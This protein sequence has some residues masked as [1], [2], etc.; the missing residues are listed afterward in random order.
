MIQ[1][2]LR[3]QRNMKT[4]SNKNSKLKYIKQPILAWNYKLQHRLP[5]KKE[6]ADFV[7]NLKPSEKKYTVF[8]TK[9]FH[10]SPNANWEGNVNYTLWEKILRFVLRKK[11]FDI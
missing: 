11:E 10:H 8:E 7:K 1:N 5:T 4:K 2:Q 9:E 6:E 3:L